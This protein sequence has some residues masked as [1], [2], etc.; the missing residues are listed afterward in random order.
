M[1]ETACVTKIQGKKATVRFIMSE[2]CHACSSKD[3]C[4]SS[5][6]RVLV[7]DIPPEMK[8]NPGDTV[9]IQVSASAHLWGLLFLVV[10]PVVLFGTGY[11]LV[12]SL[13]L[14]KGELPAAL[15]GIGG[16]LLGLLLALLVTSRGRLAARPQVIELV[17]PE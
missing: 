9:K 5:D 17:Q 14:G 6:G 7:A 1:I 13:Q 10:L 3:S 15:A 12:E 11:L 2:G 8:L 4:S 16:L